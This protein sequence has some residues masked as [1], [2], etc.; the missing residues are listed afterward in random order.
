MGDSGDVEMWPSSHELQWQSTSSWEHIAISD[1][2]NT[3]R[4]KLPVP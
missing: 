3:A 1:F 2:K 4:H